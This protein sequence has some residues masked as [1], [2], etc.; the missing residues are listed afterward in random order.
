MEFLYQAYNIVSNLRAFFYGSA[1]SSPIAGLGVSWGCAHQKSPTPGMATFVSSDRQAGICHCAGR[2]T[3]S[4]HYFRIKGK[5]IISREALPCHARGFA[6]P[7]GIQLSPVVLG[8]A[9]T[10]T[11]GLLGWKHGSQR[12][13]VLV[14]QGEGVIHFQTLTC[15]LAPGSDLNLCVLWVSRH[16]HCSM[17]LGEIYSPMAR[18]RRKG[19]D[20]SI[21]PKNAPGAWTQVIRPREKDIFVP[22]QICDSC[23]R[24]CKAPMSS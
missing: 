15:S 18:T 6:G 13:Q 4:R 1:C 12:A 21:T 8:R 24:G 16:T 11:H 5:F 14:G 23:W 2:W 19:L 22:N 17:A 7:E 20:A 3:R 10:A 9:L